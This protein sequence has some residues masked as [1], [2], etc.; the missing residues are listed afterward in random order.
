MSHLIILG[1]ADCHVMLIGPGGKLRGEINPRAR[2]R[3]RVVVSGLD[4][5]PK[6][7]VP[8][9]VSRGIYYAHNKIPLNG[10]HFFSTEYHGAQRQACEAPHVTSALAR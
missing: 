6:F 7:R 1:A 5:Y 8:V 9:S 2:P 3:R 10:E 4:L